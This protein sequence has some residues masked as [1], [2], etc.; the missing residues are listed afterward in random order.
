[1]FCYDSNDYRNNFSGRFWFPEEST[2]GFKADYYH[3][4]NWSFTLVQYPSLFLRQRSLKQHRH[5]NVDKDSAQLTLSPSWWFLLLALGT[6]TRLRLHATALSRRAAL[7]AL[8]LSLTAV[9]GESKCGPAVLLSP[10][11]RSFFKEVSIFVATWLV[12]TLLLRW[13]PTP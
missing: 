12:A 7:D 11:L 10:A 6:G 2:Y 4:C 5:Q 3:Q 13:W 1:M 8:S 9:F